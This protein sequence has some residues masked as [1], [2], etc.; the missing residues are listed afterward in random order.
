MTSSLMNLMPTMSR[1]KN[2]DKVKILFVIDTLASGG[3]ERRLTELLKALEDR[4]E[5]T[6]ELVILSDDI[7]YKE[8]FTFNIAIHQIIRCSRK[9]LAVFGQLRSILKAFNPDAVHCWESM[10]AVYLAPLCKIMKY[11]LINGMITNVPQVQNI[12]N[13]H[14]LRA[15]LTFPFSDVIVSNSKAGLEA[16]RAPS[17]KSIVIYNGFNFTRI[18]GALTREEARLGIGIRTKYTVGMVASFWQQKDYPTYYEAA[19]ILLRKRQDITFLAIGPETDSRNSINEA[20]QDFNDNFILMGKQSRIESLISAMDVC[21][22]ATFTEGT[23]NSLME[24]MAMG[25]PVVA[26]RGGGTAELINDGIEGCLVNQRDAGMMADRI[27]ILLNNSALREKLGTAA[28]TRIID[29][30]SIERMV[31]DYV[32]LYRK[33]TGISN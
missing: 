12:T 26:T 8:V 1:V 22:L 25:K 4:P 5:V 16:Y 3:K 28:R 10:T 2:R 7:H 30:F 18:E 15:R 33:V 20:G 32:A 21:V 11:P 6:S 14:W 31:N 9:D 17:G 13:R 29:A 23:S 24:Y 27:N 19:R